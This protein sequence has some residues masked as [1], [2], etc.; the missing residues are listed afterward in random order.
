VQVI[1]RSFQL[2]PSRPQGSV[3]SRRAMLMGK[4]GL[5]EARV[6]ALDAQME[7]TAVADGLEYHL[8]G[9]GVVG[10]TR[11]AHRL[12]HAARDRG[13]A[14]RMLDR[15]WRGQYAPWLGAVRTV[16]GGASGRVA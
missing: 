9:A 3:F 10:N 1:H 11:D 7:Q 15:P 12:V 4:Y 6:R 5:T 8:T 13:L 2:D 14:D 16:V